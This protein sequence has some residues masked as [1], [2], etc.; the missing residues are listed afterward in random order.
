MQSDQLH[1]RSVQHE[2][3]IFRCHRP[4]QHLT[5]ADTARQSDCEHNRPVRSHCRLPRPTAVDTVDGPVSV[6]CD[7]QSGTVYPLRTTTISC[8]ASDH[9]GNVAHGAFTINVISY[10][11]PT[12]TDLASGGLSVGCAPAP[13]TK[14]GLGTTEVTCTATDAAGNVGDTSFQVV[15]T[16]SWSGPLLPAR[17]RQFG[18]DSGGFPA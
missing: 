3:Q 10:P 4:G 7:H 14:F 9:A 15:V 6:A 1:F 16:Y 13:A 8:T 5:Q 11:P 18:R 2:Q 12:A 17:A